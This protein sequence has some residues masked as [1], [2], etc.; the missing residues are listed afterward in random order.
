[1]AT[2]DSII[3]YIGLGEPKSKCQR[4]KVGRDP[5]VEK[6]GL[7]RCHAFELGLV[8]LIQILDD[9]IVFSMIDLSKETK[10][11]RQIQPKIR[12]Y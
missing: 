4:P 10:Q 11:M 2:H 6:Y 12:T 7:K 9:L 8:T 3:P 5:P 1:L